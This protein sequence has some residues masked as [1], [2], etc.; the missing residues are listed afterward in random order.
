MY[1]Q[2]YR[3]ESGHKIIVG[4]AS[5]PTQAALIMEAER[6]KTDDELQIGMEQIMEEEDGVYDEHSDHSAFSQG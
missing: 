3:M 6:E 4:F 5:H 1:Y 2:I